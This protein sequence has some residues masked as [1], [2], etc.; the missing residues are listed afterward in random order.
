MATARPPA[1]ASDATTPGQP[2]WF[3]GL[4]RAGSVREIAGRLATSGDA[5]ATGIAGSSAAVL[6][7]LL[8]EALAAAGA[9]SSVLLVTAHVDEAEHAA[10]TLVDL[11][12]DAVRLPALELTPGGGVDMELLG[13]RYRTLLRLRGDASGNAGNA[14]D[15][16]GRPAGTRPW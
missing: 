3:A 15:A 8:P 14:G 7:G 9:P 2:A 4:M 6:A 5:S 13:E 12:V 10:A 11:G 16:A 1:P